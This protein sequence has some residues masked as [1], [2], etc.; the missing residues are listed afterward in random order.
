MLVKNVILSAL[1][2]VGREDIA[3]C[4][5]GEE[6]LGEEQSEALSALLHCYNAVEDELARLYFPLVDE[7]ECEM[8]EG[9]LYFNVLPHAPVKILALFKEGKKTKFRLYP[10]YL[11]GASGRAVVRYCYAP[12]KKELEDAAE[13]TEPV[14]ER[15]MSYGVAAEYCLICGSLECAEAWESKYR[16]EIAANRGARTGGPIPAR[17][18]I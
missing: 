14:S 3:R 10:Q 6:S 16:D 4:L 17:S 11:R 7:Q 13:L 2:L 8:K 1:S 15:M 9:T 5:I 18:W 12:E